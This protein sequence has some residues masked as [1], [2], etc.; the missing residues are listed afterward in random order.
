M[1]GFT[2]EI[3]KKT[4]RNTKNTYKKCRKSK[5]LTKEGNRKRNTGTKKI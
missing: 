2:V 3:K 5:V 1:N 4:Q